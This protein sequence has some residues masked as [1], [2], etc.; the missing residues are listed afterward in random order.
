MAD[1]AW[2]HNVRKD[3]SLKSLNEEIFVPD[4]STVVHNFL[5]AKVFEIWRERARKALSDSWHA[6][7]LG[8]PA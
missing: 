2:L 5:F 1:K 3:N 7:R 6:K 4:A 8:L